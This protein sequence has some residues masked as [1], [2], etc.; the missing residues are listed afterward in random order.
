V[1]RRRWRTGS[2][3]TGATTPAAG[4][5]VVAGWVV[6][7]STIVVAAG[8]HSSDYGGVNWQ[9]ALT[10][11]DVGESAAVHRD[12]AARRIIPRHHLRPYSHQRIFPV[13]FN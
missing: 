10:D 12:P 9:D 5:V 3:A 2:S 8:C 7:V 11:R 4:A 6:V 1:V 13:F